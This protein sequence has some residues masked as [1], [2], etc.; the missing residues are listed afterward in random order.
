MNELHTTTSNFPVTETID[1][2]IGAIEEE[3]WH[4]FARIDHAK[5]AR[6]KELELRPT[7]LI[8]FGNPEVGTLL[9]QDQQAAAIDLPMKALAWEDESG[10]TQIACNDVAWV[11]ERHKLTDDE[12]LA[13]IDDVITKV[14]S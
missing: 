11:K 10:Q 3:G 9:M 14:C 4:L 2:M 1:R 6:E 13:N 7:E 12:T 8:L 5:E